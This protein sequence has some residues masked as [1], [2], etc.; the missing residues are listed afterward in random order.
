MYTTCMKFSVIYPT[1]KRVDICINTLNSLMN[2]DFP[3]KDFE[4]I[5]VDNNSPDNTEAV[6]TKRMDEYQGQ[7]NVRD[8]KA[9]QRRDELARNLDAV[10]PKSEYLLF[11]DDDSFFDTNR[12]SCLTKFTSL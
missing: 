1:Y 11:A 6:G 12:V 2:R 7:M 8:I 10:V 9:M 4:V 5:V 3:K